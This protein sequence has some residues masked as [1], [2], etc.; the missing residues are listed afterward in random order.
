MFQLLMGISKRENRK[1]KEESVQRVM[2]ENPLNLK[3]IAVGLKE[4]TE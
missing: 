2:E 3:D 1:W 4:P